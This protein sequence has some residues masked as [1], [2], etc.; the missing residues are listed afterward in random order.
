MSNTAP[1]THQRLRAGHHLTR[2]SDVIKARTLKTTGKR[3]YDVRLRDPNGM[4]YSRTFPTKREARHY[5]GDE[6]SV[7][8][9]AGLT[10]V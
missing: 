10:R 3:V 4:E 7:R 9:V 5:E 1:V 2:R 6:R 8:A